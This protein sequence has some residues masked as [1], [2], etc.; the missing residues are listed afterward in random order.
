[1]PLDT[2]E[3]ILF[4]LLILLVVSVVV[5]GVVM[6]T[7][8]GLAAWRTLDTDGV[9]TYSRKVLVIEVDRAISDADLDRI[10]TTAEGLVGE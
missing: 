1:M 3:R 10:R 5:C 4:G 6:L 9:P 8:Q 2:G 7:P